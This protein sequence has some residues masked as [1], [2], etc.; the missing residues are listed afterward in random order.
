MSIAST[1]DEDEDD[2]SNTED[3][4]DA[5]D[6]EEEKKD[7]DEDDGGNEED[8]EEVQADD[9]DDLDQIE[10]S[11]NWIK[12]LGCN[13]PLKTYYKHMKK[14]LLIVLGSERIHSKH[15]PK[16]SENLFH[17]FCKVKKLVPEMQYLFQ[18]LGLDES[19]I[20]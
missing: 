19:Q 5:A 17:T 20:M 15:Y 3:D 10:I 7:E 14:N 6:D 1:A 16:W 4:T 11:R 12:A 13:Y 9:D 8:G 18:D 2:A